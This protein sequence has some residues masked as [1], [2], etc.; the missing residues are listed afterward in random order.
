MDPFA[1]NGLL[2]GPRF[3]PFL[4]IDAKGEVETKKVIPMDVHTSKR[5]QNRESLARCQPTGAGASICSPN[6]HQS[7]F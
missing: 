5:C 6:I 3:G 2:F 4:A 7:L 1:S